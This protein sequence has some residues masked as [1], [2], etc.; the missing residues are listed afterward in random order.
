MIRDEFSPA[1]V[2]LYWL[3]LGAGAPSGSRLVRLNGRIY[4]ALCAAVERRRP[5][6]I[7]HAGLQIRLGDAVFVV[8]VAPSPRPVAS[9]GAASWPRAR[10]AVG[11]PAG[12]GS[13]ATRFAAGTA[14]ESRTSTRPSRALFA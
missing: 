3:P 1:S 2:D 14:D 10:S 13:F 4:E 12:F 8:E 5:L 11:W 9:R 7:Y 6:D